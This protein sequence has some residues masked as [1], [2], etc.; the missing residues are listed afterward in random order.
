MKK[1]DWENSQLKTLLAALVIFGTPPLLA[2][3]LALAILYVPPEK[4]TN[5]PNWCYYN[6]ETQSLDVIETFCGDDWLLDRFTLSDNC[7]TTYQLSVSEWK[8]FFDMDCWESLYV[9]VDFGEDQ[10][11]QPAN[12]VSCTICFNGDLPAVGMT[13]RLREPSAVIREIGNY[14]VTCSEISSANAEQYGFFLTDPPEYSGVA[15]FSHNGA[16][17]YL[18]TLSDDPQFFEETLNSLLVV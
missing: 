10:P 1:Y 15:S 14:S 7:T 18:S 9:T 17:Y 13:E 4:D 16:D 2:F 12:Q 5:D 3:L 11:D 8:A 6:K